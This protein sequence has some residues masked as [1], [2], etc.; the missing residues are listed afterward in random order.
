MAVYQLPDDEI[1]FPHPSLADSNGLLAVGGDLSAGRLIL[2]YSNGIFPWYAQGEPILW[3]SPDPRA[4]L[5]PGKFKRNKS[6]RRLVSSNRFEVTFDKDFV[7]VINECG[8][9]DRKGQ[10][11]TWITGEMIQAYTRLH[12]LGL[13]HSVETWEKGELAGGLY[14]ILLGKVFFGE[15]MFHKK[16]N[17][18]KVAFWHLINRLIALDVKII[19][20]QQDT[21]HLRSMGAELIPRREFLMLV[22]KYRGYKTVF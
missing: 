19:D 14:G 9:I 21:P 13:A 4:V 12:H 22:E 11:G 16:S 20:V 1:V 15:S 18:S 3:W 7:S 17:A 2:A 8:K 5:Y 10:E 6:L